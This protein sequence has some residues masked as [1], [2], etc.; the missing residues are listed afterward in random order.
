V[1]NW[2]NGLVEAS[3]GSVAFT[4]VPRCSPLDLVRLW[5]GVGRSHLRVTHRGRVEKM[6]ALFSPLNLCFASLPSSRLLRAHQSPFRDRN[7]CFNNG[8]SCRRSSQWWCLL[9]AGGNR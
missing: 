4:V 7:Q 2:A 3:S 1:L 9:R 6:R 8:L 5:C